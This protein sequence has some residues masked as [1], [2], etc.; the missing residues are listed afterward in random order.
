MRGYS[1]PISPPAERLCETT[2][3]IRSERHLIELIHL[4]R[5]RKTC[6]NPT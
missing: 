3:H 6:S 4:P 5:M 2:R 1:E